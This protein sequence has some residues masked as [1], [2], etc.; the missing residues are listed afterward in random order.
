[1]TLLDH[2][3]EI[4]ARMRDIR[5]IEPELRR[6]FV[7]GKRRQLERGVDAQGRQFTPLKPATREHRAGTGPPLA[8]QGVN[9]DIVTRYTVSFQQVADG[10]VVLAGWPM[11]WVKYHVSG[12]RTL[13]R[14]DPSGFRPEDQRE[15]MRRLR[16]YVMRGRA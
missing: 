3:R 2:N 4:L 6:I 12:T 16:D 9:S 11:A 14:R 1:M 5:P 15:A 8:P 7:E 13:P 10:L